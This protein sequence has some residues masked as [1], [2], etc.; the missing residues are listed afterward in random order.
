MM[1]CSSRIDALCGHTNQPSLPAEK[2]SLAIVYAADACHL[3]I[4]SCALR[5][6]AKFSTL[7]LLA[8][9]L[10]VAAFA[11]ATPAFG[12]A[13]GTGTD[14]YWQTTN[15]NVNAGQ[16]APDGAW[17][18][19]FS[20]ASGPGDN[21]NTSFNNVGGSQVLP[22]S[23]NDAVFG[24]TAGNNGGS[25]DVRLNTSPVVQGIYYANVNG[26]AQLLT[27]IQS[28]VTGSSP[29]SITVGSDGITMTSSDASNLTIGP[30]T[31]GTPTYPQITFLL[32]SSQTWANYTVPF[33]SATT[34]KF[35]EIFAN[36]APAASVTTATTLTM[37]TGGIAN[38]P[39]SSVGNSS[40][41][42]AGSWIDGTISDGSSG[43]APLAIN[44]AS[45]QWSV[46]APVGGEFTPGTN[47]YSGG[48]TIGSGG[49]LR[50]VG[51]SGAGTGPIYV[52]NGGSVAAATITGGNTS[53]GNPMYI[54]GVGVTAP[55]QSIYNGTASLLGTGPL[56]AITTI[57]D[58]SSINTNNR[59][60][61]LT[62]GITL[63]GNALIT[64]SRES[65]IISTNPVNLGSNTLT[66]GGF[67]A[68]TSPTTACVATVSSPIIGGGNIIIQSATGDAANVTTF[69]ANNTYS[70]ST[71][72]TVGTLQ[73]G[74]GGATGTLGAGAISVASGSVLN[75]DMTSTQTLNQSITN[76]GILKVTAPGMVFLN[77]P[78]NFTGGKI[79]LSG[80]GNLELNSYP[81]GI[82]NTSITVGALADI[83]IGPGF[84]TN[85]PSP[86][87]T[88]P[89]PREV[90]PAADQFVRIDWSWF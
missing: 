89:I 69:G 32:S 19:N 76:A 54:T 65:L 59:I 29:E 5:L 23:G 47:T 12:Q 71:T 22:G 27:T 52:T 83:G 21:W 26:G 11:V 16:T 68:G 34:P 28:G 8:V 18:D 50:D 25:S 33:G 74:T 37:T 56:G 55:G 39:I 87:S 15:G 77:G 44:I 40:G 3:R 53:Y 41:A 1:R 86:S 31:F 2:N 62:G 45:G 85:D 38:Y 82:G 64:A 17:L 13:Y 6:S 66:I 60:D 84:I 7:T 63:T 73:V 49:V 58:G 35:M 67:L 24:G 81:T 88:T 30:T 78:L 42:T 72:V 61:T 48:T 90:L 51:A 70:G 20:G 9:A 80:G 46:A 4:R 75:Y 10:S 14:D 57:N 79:N 36:I 43:T